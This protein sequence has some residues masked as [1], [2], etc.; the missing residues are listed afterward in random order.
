MACGCPV[1]A[2]AVGGIPELIKDER[3]G[4]L[5][6]SQDVKAMAAACQKLLDNKALAARVARQA[7]QDCREFHRLENIAEQTVAMYQETID[8]FGFCN[9]A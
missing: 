5:V 9:A 7:W 4:L 8:T 6:A 2:T 1:V 3:N